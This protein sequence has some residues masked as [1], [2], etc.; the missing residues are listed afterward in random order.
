MGQRLAFTV[1]CPEVAFAATLFMA[2][3]DSRLFA[4]PSL[5]RA[6]EVRCRD[7]YAQLTRGH[8]GADCHDQ[9]DAALYG[10]FRQLW[11]HH[12]GQVYQDAVCLRILA[13][14]LLMERTRGRAVQGWTTPV[15]N[16]RAEI[17]LHPAVLHAI[18]SARLD[19]AKGFHE[20]EFGARI[21]LHAGVG[22]C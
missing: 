9:P 5:S 8:A 22:W 17:D 18:G 15:E 2:A 4:T 14:Q 20:S 21:R 11:A 16:N 7:L 1:P 3:A 10:V 12:K 13:F 6:Q 19:M